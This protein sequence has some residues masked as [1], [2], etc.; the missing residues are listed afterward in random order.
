MHV[1]EGWRTA[2]G[3]DGDVD[4]A[5]RC[6]DVLVVSRL[7]FRR[8]WMGMTPPPPLKGGFTSTFYLISISSSDLKHQTRDR[9]Y[10]NRACHFGFLVAQPHYR[11][12]RV[13]S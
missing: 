4:V 6:W 2:A 7:R 11:R 13:L 12:Q 1:D 8:E 9:S 3:R 5:G 10:S